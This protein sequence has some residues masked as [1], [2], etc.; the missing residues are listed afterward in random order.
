VV[1]CGYSG[2][3]PPTAPSTRALKPGVKLFIFNFNE[4]DL[5]NLNLSGSY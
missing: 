2:F 4:I 3:A 5:E 1:L